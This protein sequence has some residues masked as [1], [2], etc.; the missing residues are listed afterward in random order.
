MIPHFRREISYASSRAFVTAMA[1][2]SFTIRIFN[3]STLEPV[4]S[5]KFGFKS[6][7]RRG[8]AKRVND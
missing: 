5:S 1:S 4:H 6:K 7:I 8:K 3:Q 2:G